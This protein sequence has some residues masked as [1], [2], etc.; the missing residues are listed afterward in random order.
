ML[1]C[2]RVCTVY[3]LAEDEHWI[4]SKRGLTL[5]LILCK[6]ITV[7]IYISNISLLVIPIG[8][9]STNTMFLN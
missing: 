5:S 1:L 7:N 3:A 4:Y 6:F 9:C 2:G 8:P